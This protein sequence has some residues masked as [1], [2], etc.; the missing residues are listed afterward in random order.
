MGDGK[1]VLTPNFSTQTL[2][3]IIIDFWELPASRHTDVL[4]NEI[5]RNF[6]SRCSQEKRPPYLRGAISAPKDSGDTESKQQEQ[7]DTTRQIHDESL[8]KAIFNTFKKR[9]FWSSLLLLLSGRFYV[10]LC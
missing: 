7:V 4:A 3:I 9:I 6:Y 2:Q 8:F 10:S 5:E 1:F